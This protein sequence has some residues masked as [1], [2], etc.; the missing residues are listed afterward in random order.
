MEG[1]RTRE[2]SFGKLTSGPPQDALAL[3]TI[4]YIQDRLSA[5]RD[6]PDRS[7]EDSEDKLN[8]QLCKFLDSHARNESP[9]IRF[10]REEH[11]VGRRRADLSVSRAD[12]MVLEARTYSI[13]DPFL[14]IECKRLPAPSSDREREYVT[15]GTKRSGGIQRFKLGLYARDAKRAALIGYAQNKTLK[16]WHGAINGWIG[17]LIK[18]IETDVCGWLPGEEMG[19][20]QEDSSTGFGTCVSKHNRTSGSESDEIELHHLWICM[21]PSAGSP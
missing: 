6:D 17:D 18:G 12:H 3:K 10:D 2:T 5:W 15:G 19:A 11:Q 21:T 4:Q 8:A 1:G 20:L 16:H 7:H 14:I 9:M 13:Y